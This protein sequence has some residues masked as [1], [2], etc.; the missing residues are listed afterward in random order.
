MAETRQ[1][2][3]FNLVDRPDFPSTHDG[4]IITSRDLSKHVNALMTRIFADYSGCR[5]YVDQGSTGIDG[6]PVTMNQNHPVQL[7]LYFNLGNHVDGERRLYAFR[8]ITDSIKDAV[9]EGKK[10]SYIAQALGHNVAITQNKSS[11]ITDDGIDILSSMLWYEVATRMSKNPTAKEFNKKGII[12]EASTANGNTPYT[13]PN[14][15]RTVYNV[16]RYV[17]ICSILAMLFEDDDKKLVYSVT[18]IKPIMPMTGGYVVPNVGGDQK[19]L[20]NVSRINQ[21]TFFDLCNEIGTFSSSNGLNITTDT[22]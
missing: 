3:T 9:G 4:M 13:T 15:Q 17:D 16:V 22:Y 7:E 21:E 19:W 11:E 2:A 6:M 5:I 8:P 10:R 12:V 14:A 1:K 20:F 18:P